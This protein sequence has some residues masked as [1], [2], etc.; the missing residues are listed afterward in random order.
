MVSPDAEEGFK[1]TDRRRRTA[2]SEEPPTS[3]LVIEPERARAETSRPEVSARAV[4]PTSAPPPEAGAERNLTGLFVM[5]ADSAAMALGEAPDPLT[6]QVHHDVDQAAMMIDLLV[7]LR[8][9]TEGHR[10]P[11]ESQV[12]DEVIY[13]LQLRYVAATQPSARRPGPS[14]S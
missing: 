8:E 3:P 1:V 7:L 11:E 6:G 10:T 5:L 14:R 4:E 12:L 9:K 2:D 13:G